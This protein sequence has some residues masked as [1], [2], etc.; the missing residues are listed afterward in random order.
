MKAPPTVKAEFDWDEHNIR[1]GLARLIRELRRAV[2]DARR[3]ARLEDGRKLTERERAELASFHRWHGFLGRI[4]ALVKALDHPN[5]ERRRERLYDLFAA[6]GTA[7]VFEVKLKEPTL[8]RLAT[9]PAT[10][11]KMAKGGET[12][13]IVDEALAKLPR[14]S[15]MSDRAV[16]E[17][18]HKE[19]GLKARTIRGHLK[20]RPRT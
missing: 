9:G 8:S 20:G 12:R 3:K 1:V 5:P 16:A 11:G 19:T 10:A 6:L 2:A 17:H 14:A 18:L 7:A 15:Q 13:Q 4:P